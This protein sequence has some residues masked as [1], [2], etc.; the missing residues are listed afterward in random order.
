MGRPS[1]VVRSARDRWF[2]ARRYTPVLER[3]FVAV[4]RTFCEHHFDN[5]ESFLKG[6]S[7]VCTMVANA[8]PSVEM[9]IVEF[10][11][12]EGRVTQRIWQNFK[13]WLKTDMGNHI[14][15]VCQPWCQY[16]CQTM[17]VCD[18]CRG[19][20]PILIESESDED[21]QSEEGGS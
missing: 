11:P 15:E 12:C 8:D 2:K 3:L 1:R 9:K 5:F 13:K 16:A 10:F 7:E 18:D 19:G 20:E 4:R 17:M 6:L 14:R 21:D